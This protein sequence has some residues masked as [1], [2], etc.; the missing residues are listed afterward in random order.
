MATYLVVYRADTERGT[1]PISLFP[2]NVKPAGFSGTLR[3]V[4][5]STHMVI[6]KDYRKKKK[7]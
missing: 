3:A 5:M 7:S 4:Y 1:A 6:K 2:M